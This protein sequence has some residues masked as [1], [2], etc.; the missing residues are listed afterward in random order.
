MFKF[1]GNVVTI[2][3][4]SMAILF[5]SAAASVIIIGPHGDMS[6]ENV[7]LITSYI[8]SLSWSVA[9]IIFINRYVIK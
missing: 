5:F 2:L 1:L 8:L 9:A 4:L 3:I 6:K 7:L